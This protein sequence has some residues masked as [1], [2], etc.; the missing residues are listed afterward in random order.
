MKTIIVAYW[1]GILD[2][3]TGIKQNEQYEYSVEKRN[4]IIDLV[5]EKGLN[6]ML[7]QIPSILIIYIDDKKFQQR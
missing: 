2:N 6:V 7:Y 4:E 5:I 1:Y 3:I